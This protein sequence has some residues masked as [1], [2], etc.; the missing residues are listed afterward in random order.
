[1]L[2]WIIE[3]E[4]I[5]QRLQRASLP[6]VLYGMGNGAEKIMNACKSY[7]IP[8][9]GVFASD[10][11]V[12]GQ[13]FAGFSVLTLREMEAQ[14]E[15]FIV[16]LAFG[17]HDAAVIEKIKALAR[18]HPLLLPDVPVAGPGLFNAQLVQENLAAIRRV[19][20][21][22]ADEDSRELFHNLINYK[23]S[24]E[25]SYLLKTSPPEEAWSLLEI[26][27][28]ESY[29]DVGAYTGDTIETFLNYCGGCFRH[30]IALEADAK[31][32]VK[33]EKKI[34]Y[35]QLANVELHQKAAYCRPCELL[36]DAGSG[37]GSHI[38]SQ[39]KS[40]TACDLD[41]IVGERTVSLLKMDIE[42]NEREA[43]TGAEK[44]LQ[45]CRPRLIV[46]AYHRID[47]LWVIP[48]Q[49]KKIEPSYALY[50]RRHPALPA[51][52]VNVYGEAKR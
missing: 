9:A 26:G 51:W 43:L 7:G 5:W 50:L 28:R 21:D 41:H 2:D 12:R 13:S 38:G 48:E 49:I 1:M 34:E 18:R 20:A 3:K 19:E 29:L 32:F 17:T 8:I 37:K 45:R 4:D 36:F 44:I 35:L 23:L 33:L 16:L 39:G 47:D 25:L 22:W 6:I 52:D 14:Y 11:F 31:N 10:E 46:S 24:G 15:E 40:V 42:G 30:I 27:Q